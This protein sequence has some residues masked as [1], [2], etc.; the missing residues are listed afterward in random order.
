MVLDSLVWKFYNGNEE[1]HFGIYVERVGDFISRMGFENNGSSIKNIGVVHQGLMS[2]HKE[3]IEQIID[4]YGFEDRLLKR[5][6]KTIS[7]T[8][9]LRRCCIKKGHEAYFN[10]LYENYGSEVRKS[11]FTKEYWEYGKNYLNKGQ[12]KLTAAQDS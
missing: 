7:S 8:M 2:R 5:F 10:T 3:R 4:N 12:D 1:D 11:I 9:I 6:L